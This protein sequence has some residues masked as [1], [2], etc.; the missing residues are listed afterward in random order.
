[1]KDKVI[2][3]VV[4]IFF[5]LLAFAASLL[6]SSFNVDGSTTELLSKDNILKALRVFT[7]VS[8]AI[9][10]FFFACKTDK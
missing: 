2:A 4:V 6:K 10:V 8:I 9:A 3:T 7:F 5:I 1:M